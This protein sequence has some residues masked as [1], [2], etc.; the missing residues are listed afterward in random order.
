MAETASGNSNT[1]AGG[2][3]FSS[4]IGGSG[5]GT[6]NFDLP[7]AT[8][9]NINNRAF[10][11]LTANSAQNKAFLTTSMTRNDAAVKATSDTAFD[12][13]NRGLSTIRTGNLETG[14]ALTSINATGQQMSIFRSLF[15]A[16]ANQPK[17]GGGCFITTAICDAEGKPDDCDELQTLR[18]FRDEIMLPNPALAGLV[19]EYYAIAPA[20]V[21]GIKKLADNGRE[22]FQLLK[23]QY[24]DNVIEAVKAGDI[25]VAVGEYLQMVAVARQASGV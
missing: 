15:A 16:Q 5:G 11:F 17:S 12:Y 20:I 23:M 19:R 3:N 13:L 10:D 8:I 24:L 9:A 2:I 1:Y 6:I 22:V 25:D 7:L 4:T 14:S 21:E 18:K